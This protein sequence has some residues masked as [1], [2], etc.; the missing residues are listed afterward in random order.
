MCMVYVIQEMT[1]INE[2][3]ELWPLEMGTFSTVALTFD[4]WIFCTLQTLKT[5]GPGSEGKTRP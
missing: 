4:C 2:R 3:I 1:H 5:S